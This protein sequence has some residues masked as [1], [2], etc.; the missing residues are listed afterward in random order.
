MT[1]PVVDTRPPTGHAGIVGGVAVVGAV[2]LVVS[3]SALSLA[4]LGALLLT[5]GT[6]YGS[7][8]VVGL[9]ALAALGGVAVGAISGVGVV[10][11]LVATAGIVVAWDAARQSLDLAETVGR[12]ADSQ[13][14]LSTHTGVAA[15]VTSIAA[16]L[17]YGIYLVVGDGR[18]VGAL[19]LLLFGGV[20]LAAALR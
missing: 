17:G 10:F 19:V 15:G 14:A 7:G 20:L 1:D 18:P 2:A 5:A 12:E 13:R 9:G 16:G 11:L 3:A 6:V 4:L 8:R